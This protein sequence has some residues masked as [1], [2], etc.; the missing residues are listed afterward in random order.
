MEDDNN[1]LNFDDA[2]SLIDKISEEFKVEV[3]VPSINK[4][5]WF[6]EL[7]AKQQKKFFSIVVDESIYA[8]KFS[9]VFYEIL[10]TNLI[11]SDG[12]KPDD[13]EKLDII[14]KSCIAICFRK[15]IS[16]KLKIVFDKDKNISNEVLLDDII[17]KFKTLKYQKTIQIES[18]NNSI[19]VELSLPT[20]K[21]ESEYDGEVSKNLNKNN[22]KTEQEIKNIVIDAFLT[23]TSKY[24]NKIV[25]SNQ[26]ILFKTLTLNQKIR[27]TEKI[28]AVILQKILDS[29]SRWKK[30]VDDVLT[31]KHEEYTSTISIDGILFLN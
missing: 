10:K 15:Q 29:A 30:L 3:W 6:K 9:S 16:N 2:L 18:K 7:D 23:E 8:S 20:I 13:L 11:E 19:K 31:V 22:N 24:I 27:I 25:I 1:I 17:S 28:P 5:I 26:E 12:F 21:E 14:D 4:N